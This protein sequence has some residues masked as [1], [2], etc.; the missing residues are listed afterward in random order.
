LKINVC[1]KWGRAFCKGRWKSKFAFCK[2]MQNL[3]RSE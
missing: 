3:H 2:R 1:A